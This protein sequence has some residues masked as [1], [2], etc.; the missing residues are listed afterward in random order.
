MSITKKVSVLAVGLGMVGT[1]AA[2]GSSS[3]DGGGS[4]SGG[5]GTV[6][7]VSHDSWAA[8]KDVLA[9]FEKQ[10]GYKVK[11]LEDGDAG[12]AVN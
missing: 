5:S 9:A 10:S 11:V 2:C 4:G 8:S 3:D 6:T 1:L 12:Q 7:L